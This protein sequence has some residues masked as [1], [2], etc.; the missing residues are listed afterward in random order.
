MKIRTDDKKTAAKITDE[1]REQVLTAALEHPDVGTRRLAHILNDQ[2]VGISRTSVY[3]ILRGE[4]LQTIEQRSRYLEE[5]WLVGLASLSERQLRAMEDFNPCLRER[6]NRGQVSGE[7]IAQDVAALGK[8]GEL[9]PVYLHVAVDTAGGLAFALLADA[10][11]ADVAAALIDN[12]VLPFCME[13]SVPIRAMESGGGETFSGGENHPYERLLEVN[14][15]EHHLR[16]RGRD[17]NGFVERFREAVF[18]EFL[19]PSRQAHNYRHFS[20]LQA[21][22]LQWLRHYNEER[23]SPGYPLNG[24]T[25]ADAF[26]AVRPPA[27][28]STGD[29]RPVDEAEELLKISHLPVA[30]PAT[31]EKTRRR[32]PPLFLVANLLLLVLIL[33]LGY[34]AGRKIWDVHRQGGAAAPAAEA[35]VSEYEPAGPAKRATALADY[36]PIWQRDIFNTAREEEGGGGEDIVLEDIP[37][38]EKDIGLT[39]LGTVVTDESRRNYAIIVEKKNKEQLLYH[40]GDQAGEATIK[41]ILRNSVIIATDRGDEKLIMETPESGPARRMPYRALGPRP[42]QRTTVARAPAR[43][44]VTFRVKRDEV[45]ASIS[46]VDQ[47]LEETRVTP[48]MRGGQPEGFRIMGLNSR[49]PL[50][51]MG[52]RNG[53]VIRAV[54]GNDVSGPDQAPDF[55]QSLLDGSEIDIQILRRGRPW[56]VKID[57]Q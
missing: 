56:Q 26:Q 5:Q 40:E 7:L 29:P 37:E 8:V 19:K 43:S 16:E 34:T 15:I 55:F 4:R 10:P 22:F 20:D 1:L 38:A 17:T 23:P 44:P 53:D 57:M 33:V 36:R 32:R 6:E 52:L 12:Q 27:P 45:L 3:N 11:D 51:R 49:S 2:G 14:R 47:L 21:D 39:L 54:N 25:P 24:I 28:L 30:N 31:V 13:H 48:Y 46:G 42:V 41:K 50:A 18:A 9:G 35:P